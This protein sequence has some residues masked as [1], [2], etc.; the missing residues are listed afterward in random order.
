VQVS[1]TGYLSH[2]A[3]IEDVKSARSPENFA[4]AFV[5]A[6]LDSKPSRLAG[7]RQLALFR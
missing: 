5:L 6:A 1:D 2:F 4:R 7:P 3:A